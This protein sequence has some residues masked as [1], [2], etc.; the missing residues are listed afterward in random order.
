MKSERKKQILHMNTSM[1][2]LEKWCIDDLICKAEI[3]T[4]TEQMYGHQRG[5]RG[6]GYDE[7]GG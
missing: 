2:N 6:S 4:Q 3:E 7:L 1:W 5:G